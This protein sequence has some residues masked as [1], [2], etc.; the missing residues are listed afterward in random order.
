MGGLARRDLWLL[1][2][3]AFAT[4][5][6]LFLGSE[7]VARIFWPEQL[8]NAC[9]LF[10]SAVGVRYRP[11]C[12]TTM[13]T[14]EGPWYVASY[15][16]CGYRS[17]APCGPIPPG[18]RRVALLGTST[19][20]GYLVE[21]P[22]T[23]GAQIETDLTR[24]CGAPVQVQN[25]GALAPFGHQLLL[26][27][28]EALRLHPNA[29]VLIL[30]PFD[31][32]DLTAAAATDAPT[33]IPAAEPPAGFAKHVFDELK[34]SRALTVAQHFLFRNLNVYLSLYL[35][36]G[37]KADFLRSPF[38][39]KWQERLQA[40]DTI[41]AGLSARAQRAGVPLTL[42]YV[43]QEA[44]VA[45]MAPGRTAP[46]GVNPAALPAAIAQIAARHNAIFVDSS[47]ALR[48]HPA[49]ERLYYQVD[50][51]L[52]GKGQPI[53]GSYIA[54]T[55][56]GKREGPFAACRGTVSASLEVPQ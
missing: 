19:S 18:T 48:T 23:M 3:I 54:Q 21:Y 20:E 24:L 14:P 1:P 10:D 5:V 35:R 12:S 43:P 8:F 27:M 11:N 52:S 55:L 50:G 31:L 28:D 26:R 6:V 33:A 49:P 42:A 4:V 13:K 15:N 34:D 39:P 36:Y 37:D 2:L 45:L 22:N 17:D 32:E 47:L 40:L 51:H 7:A 53:V 56:A 46:A 30:A 44:Q 9:R 29:V 38:T 25:L 41:V 16:A